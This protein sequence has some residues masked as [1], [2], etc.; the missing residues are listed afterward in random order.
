MV[1]E[2]GSVGAT[3][4][5]LGLNQST[6]SYSLEKLREVFSDPLFIKQGRGI[7]PTAKAISIAPQ[8][9]N[10]LLE[11]EDV[12]A[13]DEYDPAEDTSELTI[14]TNVME[15]L[16]VC[17]DIFDSILE[18]APKASIRFLEL[19]SRDNI[20]PLLES[21]SA[22]LVISVR[23]A[24]LP[25]SLQTHPLLSFDQVCFYDS[26]FRDP[27]RSVEDFCNANHATLD[28]GGDRKSTIDLTLEGLSLSRNIKVKA[29]NIVALSALMKGTDLVATMQS[30]LHRHAM[31]DFGYSL[32]PMSLPLVNFDLIWHRRS[33]NSLRNIWL[34]KT[35]LEAVSNN[36]GVH[37]R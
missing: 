2:T 36:T 23:L 12:I 10:I 24:D 16:P 29:P 3:A 8:I 35:V 32:P 17:D 20:R 14:A 31:S 25:S 11:F 6:V 15:L 21:R 26:N 9:A 7:I 30:G 27:I 13:S 34:R 19:G 37:F 28:F 22:N 18:H 33:E 4:I 1:M 5:E